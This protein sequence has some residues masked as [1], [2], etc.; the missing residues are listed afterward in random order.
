MST[1]AAPA[2]LTGRALSD[3]QS[4]LG[5][6]AT[7][8][9]YAHSTTRAHSSVQPPALLPVAS[10]DGAGKP[11]RWWQPSLT[12]IVVGAQA[13]SYWLATAHATT[14]I[15]PEAAPDAPEPD[16][17]MQLRDALA[18]I[19]GYI[20]TL[21][22]PE[23]RISYAGPKV[24]ALLGQDVLLDRL[25]ADV[26]AELQVSE[27]LQA[28]DNTYQTGQPF[29]VRELVR[30]GD[31]E[32]PHY[33]NVSLQPLRDAN[34]QIA[35]VLVFGQDVTHRVRQ[36]PPP[37]ATAPYQELY[38]ELVEQLPHIACISSAE[39]MV[40]YLSPQWFAY[41]GQVAEVLRTHD[42]VDALDSDDWTQVLQELPEHLRKGKPWN[43]SAR[44]RRHDGEYRRHLT[45]MRP[46]RNE[47]GRISRWLGTMTDV[48]DLH[49][50]PATADP[51][52]VDPC[53]ELKDALPQLVWT[54]KPDGAPDSLN[55]AALTYSGSETPRSGQAGPSMFPSEDAAL[56]LAGWQP[57][58]RPDETWEQQSQ[59][60]RSD[61]EMRWF[62]H[63]AQPLR[64]GAGTLVQWIGTST[65][66][67]ELKQNELR[68]QQQNEDLARNSRELDAFV[69]AAANE[70]RQPIHNLQAL[71][72]QMRE[73][74]TFH[75][76][77]ANALLVMADNS[78]SRWNSTVNN[79]MQ[80]VKA[81]QQHQLPPEELSLATLTREALLGLHPRLR[82][83][84]GEVSTH[85]QSLPT[86]SYV[87]PHL[88]SIITNLLS[89]SIQQHDPSRP[90]RL[91][92]ES[93]PSPN[94]RAQ[95]VVQD[96]GLGIALP[97]GGSR[98]SRLHSQA[99]G[100]GADLYL[101]HRIV[102]D[103]GGRLDVESVPGEGTT[104]CV[105]L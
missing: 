72:G 82:A 69:R 74:V 23:H 100:S 24:A 5:P 77:D 89:N 28:L 42:W 14:P 87:R 93:K 102:E 83:S 29:V 54:L 7:A 11:L 56:A 51:Q 76:P 65:D 38:Q 49:P 98:S 33:F 104:F 9:A 25:A 85:F 91:R 12:R 61:G 70:L 43:W 58:G 17:V 26:L 59:L 92:L 34:Q 78:L 99:P 30:P 90:L 73:A 53:E 39:G 27:A 13:G 95:L 94:G 55:Q 22:G 37:A 96:N 16:E 20:L 15:N 45:Q 47:A 75:D 67:E 31:E 66:I 21:R 97:R 57:D 80:L 46:V 40:E 88:L 84:G 60:Q 1:A 81:Q 44:I 18:H 101:I 79:L 50:D 86:V 3:V 8:W 62:L 71:F 64:D 41:T 63:R 48:Q 35:G 2:A 4:Q 36:A 52:A 19:P 32:A 10:A 105:T 68:L 103:H 6:V